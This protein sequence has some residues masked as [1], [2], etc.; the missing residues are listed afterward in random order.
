ML[1]RASN[2]GMKNSQKNDVVS[3]RLTGHL[4]SDFML[5][6]AKM[7]DLG[8]GALQNP[9]G[10]NSRKISSKWRQHALKFD[11]PMFTILK[12]TRKALKY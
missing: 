4:F 12:M 2:F 9:R 10:E 3:R 7:I 11:Q 6:H 5:M 1:L 8:W